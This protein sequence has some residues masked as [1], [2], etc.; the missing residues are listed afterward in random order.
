MFL[1]YFGQGLGQYSA[2]QAL[3]IV[4]EYHK[5]C[6]LEDLYD[7]NKSKTAVLKESVVR[8]VI[9]QLV[10][11]LD[12]CLR[13]G[14]VH[15]DVR[16]ANIAIR[17]RSEKECNIVLIDFGVAVYHHSE[18]EKHQMEGPT[19]TPLTAAPEVRS[20]KPYNYKCDCW[21]VGVVSYFLLWGNY[22]WKGK[23]KPEMHKAAKKGE[24]KFK[25]GDVWKILSRNATNFI[26]QLIQ[27]EPSA[28][29]NYREMLLHDWLKLPKSPAT[30]GL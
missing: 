18:I 15:R 7:N 30:K 23:N 25:R 11:A 22:P 13:Q 5:L 29:K 6:T 26:A 24:C 17:N 4:M 2:P 8:H 21:S 19:G 14:V 9:R 10:E 27:V 12:Y 20:E 1:T 28:R 16:L 3:L